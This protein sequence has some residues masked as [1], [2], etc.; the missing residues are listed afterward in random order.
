MSTFDLYAAYYDLLYRD[1]DYSEEVDYINSL[2]LAHRGVQ[3]SSILELGCGTGGH[4]T[5][6]AKSGQTVHG[7]DLSPHMVENAKANLVNMPVDLAK[8][9]TFE[10]GD[11]RTFRTD[12]KFDVAISLFHVFCYQTSNADLAAAFATARF[13][14]NPGGLLIFD[15]WYGPGVLSDRPRTVDKIVEDATIQVNRHTE[16]IVHVNDNCVDVAFDV[17]ISLKG[18]AQKQNVV[19]HHLMRYLFLPEIKQYLD[20][21]GFE[22]CDSY[23][24][25]TQNPMVD[26]DWY[27]CVAAR[28]I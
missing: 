18:T 15:F 11:I 1:K 23:A 20:L 16:S 13:H 28:A 7:I 2:I 8:R 12:Q 5:Y 17:D 10:L 22:F 25:L 27:G 6:L 19:E 14:L 24:W 26:G 3:E 4:A 9:L 21:N